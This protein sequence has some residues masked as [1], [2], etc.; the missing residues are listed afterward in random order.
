MNLAIFIHA[1]HPIA[2]KTV[3]AG[4]EFAPL[5]GFPLDV[6]MAGASLILSG[7]MER[8]RGLRIGLSHGGGAMA[9]LLPRMEQ[10]WQTLPMLRN[11]LPKAPRDY[12]R[13]F[14]Y[15]SNVYDGGLLNYIATHMAPGRVFVGTD[16]PYTIM[17]TDPA[18]YIASA[19]LGDT[20]LH[21]VARHAAGDFLQLTTGR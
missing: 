5:V 20:V 4:P 3:A 7:M 1:L 16:Y 11:R 8:H 19:G 14:Y 12:V 17:Q 21:S 6:G 10:G 13:L 9:V 15:D 2:T 18:G